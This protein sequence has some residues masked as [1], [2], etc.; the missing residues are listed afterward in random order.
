MDQHTTR[1]KV[2]PEENEQKL[3]TPS[4]ITSP[5]NLR[6]SFKHKDN[7]AS[8][9]RLRPNKKRKTDVGDLQESDVSPAGIIDIHTQ[10]D[11]KSQVITLLAQIDE[12]KKR[13]EKLENEKD[14]RLSNSTI[15][16]HDSDSYKRERESEISEVLAYMTESESSE[17][18]L[19]KTIVVQD[20]PI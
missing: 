15:S 19:R 17:N 14:K 11:Y 7:R 6:S 8:S 4:P 1:K 3:F 16:S 2:S 18:V 5:Y 13:V 9:K 20:T 12:L 10:T